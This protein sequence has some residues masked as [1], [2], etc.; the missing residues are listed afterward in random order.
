MRALVLHGVVVEGSMGELLFLGRFFGR[1]LTFSGSLLLHENYKIID[2][3]DLQW[4]LVKGL[5]R[6]VMVQPRYQANRFPNF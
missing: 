2:M 6:G 4:L 1:G 5:S 3:I